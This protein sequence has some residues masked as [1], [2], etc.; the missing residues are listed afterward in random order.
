MQEGRSLGTNR[1]GAYA[2]SDL[3]GREGLLQE[4]LKKNS[5]KGKLLRIAAVTKR[6]GLP[7]VAASK[8][9]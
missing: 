7:L 8:G 5:Q 6:L 9:C 2:R 4:V 1:L 3:L